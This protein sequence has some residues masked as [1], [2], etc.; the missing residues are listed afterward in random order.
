MS[1]AFVAPE[2]GRGLPAGCLR[3][4]PVRELALRVCGAE[5]RLLIV[6]A[7]RGTVSGAPLPRGRGS[8]SSSRILRYGW[9]EF[10]SAAT[11]PP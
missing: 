3:S 5:R 11:V 10:A 7:T 1:A 8:E 4:G 9:H 6:R 2:I